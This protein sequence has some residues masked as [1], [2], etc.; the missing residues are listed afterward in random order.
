MQDS[1]PEGL[2]VQHDS[3]LYREIR[4]FERFTLVRVTHTTK[5]MGLM[6]DVGVPKNT[7]YV[8]WGKIRPVK[9]FE[10][11]RIAGIFDDGSMIFEFSMP[12]RS[13]VPQVKDRIELHG[14]QSRQ[15]RMRYLVNQILPDL[16]I[17]IGRCRITPIGNEGVP[18]N[19]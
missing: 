13:R 11:D 9:R 8:I 5:E 15:P 2:L 16:S 12:L 4:E 19:T 3:S 7:R 18:E 10:F 17:T 1:N 14:V 6:E